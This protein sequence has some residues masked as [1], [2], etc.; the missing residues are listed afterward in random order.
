MFQ[1]NC[2]GWTLDNAA[3]VLPTFEKR[4]ALEWQLS[5]S[6]TNLQVFSCISVC[7]IVFYAYLFSMNVGEHSLSP[8]PTVSL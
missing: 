6:H 5:V 2:A 1:I 3:K 7:I 4:A 8:R